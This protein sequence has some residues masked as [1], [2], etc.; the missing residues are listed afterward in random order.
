MKQ[1]FLLAQIAGTE[2]AIRSCAVESVIAVGEIIKI[3]GSDPTISGLYAL[4]SRVL[5]LIDSQFRVTGKAL[6]YPKGSFAIVVEV[7]N[8]VYG[9]I[10]DAVSDVVQ[11]EEKDVRLVS[12]VD[13]NWKTIVQSVVEYEGRVIMVVEP[14]CLVSTEFDLAA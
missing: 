1:L 5:T 11:I 3:P 13:P 10:V 12:R 6:S 9:L 14:I 7:E 4:R 2:I 8:H